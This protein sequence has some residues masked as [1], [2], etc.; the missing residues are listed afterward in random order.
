MYG[1]NDEGDMDSALDSFTATGM[2]V[3]RTWAFSDFVGPQQSYVTVFQNWST[4]PPVIQETQ[5]WGL[6]RLDYVVAGAESRGIKL[7]LTL[8]NNWSNY[9][10]SEQYVTSTLGAGQYHDLFFTNPTVI[11]YYKNYVST[12]VNRYK[13]SPAVFAW[14]LINEPRCGGSNLQASPTCN[15][16]TITNWVS[17]LSAYIKSIDPWHMV[18]VGDEGFLN[19]PGNSVYVYSGGAGVDNYALTALSTIDFGTFHLYPEQ[20]GLALSWG[21]Q[22]IL[23]HA[24]ISVVLNKPMLQEEYGVTRASGE[25]DTY[26]LQYHNT[27]FDNQIAGDMQWQF[28]CTVPSWGQSSDDGYAIYPSDTFDYQTF[29]IEWEQVMASKN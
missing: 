9:G 11:G 1:P 15:V 19:E 16:N 4:V 8:T 29:F 23:D 6:P 7:I 24:N 17:E 25:R 10:G 28:G 18:S 14:E 22:W 5:E 13:D 2:K 12:L 3:L 26:M 27:T 21:N 20:W